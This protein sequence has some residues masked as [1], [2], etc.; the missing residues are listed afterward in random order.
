[1][2]DPSTLPVM[3]IDDEEHL[4]ITASQT[5]ELGG[6]T[7]HC[8]ES[9]E[10]AL[11][12]LTLNFPG[13]IV[14]D[15]RMPG[16]DG[17]TL[18]R[19]LR[20][21][22]PTLP[23]ILITGHGDISTAVEAM[24]AGAWDFLEKPFAGDQLLDVVRRAIEK[25]QLSLEN[26]RLKAELEA[27]QA[28][29]GPRLVGRTETISRLAAMIQRISQ[30]ET[31]V[32]LF[33]ETGTGKDLVARA[34]HE[35][36]RRRPHPFMAINC[37]AVPE[38]TIE[39]ELFG[40]EKGAFTGA[41]ERRIGKFEHANGGTVFLDE[42]ES[43]PLA[44]QVKL[45]RVLQE[46][47]IERLGA[48]DV[49]KL[50]IRVIAATKVDLK[51]ASE[52]GHFREDLYYRLNVVTLPLPALRER[53]EDIPLLFQHFAVIASNRSGLEAPPLDSQ[54][55]AA[56]LAH[57]WPGN[58]RELRNLAERY[59]LLGAAFD[60]RLAALLEGDNAETQTT[61][62]TRQ[63]ELFEKS[64]ISQSLARHHGRV[65]QVCEH[66]CLPR[67]TLYDKLKKHALQAE[68]YRHKSEP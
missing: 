13:V 52:V 31:D 64:L 68:D 15:I 30:V 5:L 10:Q 16:M 67:K 26:D 29:L 11:D 34:I 19:T 61:S 60:Y 48:N 4:R 8:F 25:R 36:S 45:L 23:I 54:A 28:A 55:I 21:R 27:Q 39:S 18:L 51:A 2:H 65:T 22:D 58:V 47:S 62:L 41:V 17:M 57:D 9:A 53:R 6:Y 20:E 43:M 32:L 56:L 3:V 66:L 59:V 14:S 44:L 40:H 12:A 50:D 7:P 49:I 38:N 46:R 37:G 42:I 24:R 1:M 63:V 33:G 35:R